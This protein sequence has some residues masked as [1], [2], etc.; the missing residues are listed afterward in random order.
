MAEDLIFAK[1]VVELFGG[2]LPYK[3]LMKY[4]HEHKIKAKKIGCRYVFSK[5][6][7]LEW[8]ARNIGVVVE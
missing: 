7:V 2:K 5:Q 8:A 1:D 6:L 3:T 4:V